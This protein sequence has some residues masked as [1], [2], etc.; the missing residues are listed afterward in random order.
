[1][2]P[3]GS[4]SA[5]SQRPTAAC[6]PQVGL[7]RL[8]PELLPAS[9]G[10]GAGSLPPI[11][12]S[13][14]ALIRHRIPMVVAPTAEGAPVA[15]SASAAGAAADAGG[16]AEAAAASNG[17]AAAAAAAAAVGSAAVGPW[18]I[19]ALLERLRLA[20]SDTGA[21]A[22][23]SSSGGSSSSDSMNGNAC[24]GSMNGAAGGGGGCLLEVVEVKNTCP[25]GHSRR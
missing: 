7:C 6:L 21:C 3:V 20:G 8:Q 4:V 10:F 9:W 23:S 16:R 25:F 12:A 22:A 11:G 19:D 14:D 18:D 13:P 15:G 5:H 1:M 17:A 24:S 2:L